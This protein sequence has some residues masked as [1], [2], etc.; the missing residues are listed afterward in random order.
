MAKPKIMDLGVREA[1]SEKALC[2]Y[3]ISAELGLCK[4]LE[5]TQG[6]TYC[7]L[8]TLNHF[9]ELHESTVGINFYFL[10]Y[11]PR[12]PVQREEIGN[13]LLLTCFIL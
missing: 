7:D 12:V 5:N 3:S 1:P 10:A 9:S 8:Y 11:E 4:L 6:P 2:K 13:I